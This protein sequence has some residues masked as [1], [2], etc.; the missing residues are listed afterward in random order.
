MFLLFRAARRYMYSSSLSWPAP[1]SLVGFIL[2]CFSLCIINWFFPA[3]FPFFCVLSFVGLIVVFLSLL[4]FLSYVV[5]PR[6]VSYLSFC[7][8]SGRDLDPDGYRLNLI[9]A[10]CL[11]GV[12]FFGILLDIHAFKELSTPRIV[13][14]FGTYLT[15]LAFFHWSEFFFAALTSPSRADTD[16][17]LLNHSPEYLCALT[18]SFTEYWLEVFFWPAKTTFLALNFIGLS[19]CLAGEVARKAAMLTAAGNFS[20]YVEHTRRRDHRLVRNGV[21]AW[22]RHPAYAGWFVWSLGTQLLLVNPLCSV[23]YPIAAYHFFR[24][25]VY[26]EELSLVAFF[27]DGYRAYQRE[28]PTGLPFIYGYVDNDVIR[29]NTH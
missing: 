1:T 8:N 4:F 13:W 25:R 24:D 19:I 22:C 23:M 21:Y 10:F 29:A 2:G 3:P 9:I 5:L 14:P 15:L 26:S 12:F 28:V 20:H 18:L 6:A 11:G 17:Y 7:A 27:G 16:L